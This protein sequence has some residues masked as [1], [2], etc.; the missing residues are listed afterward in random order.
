M[1]HDD[2]ILILHYYNKTS[3]QEVTYLHGNHKAGGGGSGQ[4]LIEVGVGGLDGGN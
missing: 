1:I 3:R 2:I 4:L